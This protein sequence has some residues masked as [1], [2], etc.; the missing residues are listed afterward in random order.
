MFVLLLLYIVLYEQSIHIIQNCINSSV[1]L[2]KSH[3]QNPDRPLS[4]WVNFIYS[5]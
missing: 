2:L 4:K 1:A 5:Q 3:M